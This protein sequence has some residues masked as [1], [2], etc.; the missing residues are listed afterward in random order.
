[1]STDAL[2]SVA[3]ISPDDHE[4]LAHLPLEAFRAVRER[5]ESLR[6][7]TP[8]SARLAV[9]ALYADLARF[10]TLYMIARGGS[11]HIGSSFSS[12]DIV[13]WVFLNEVRAAAGDRGFY[14]ADHTPRTPA[15]YFSSKGHD[16][17]GLYA[18]L[19]GLELLDWEKL[20][21]LRRLGG[22][23]GHPDIKTP[24]MEANTGSLG[25]GVSKAKGIAFANRLAGHD[26]QRLYVMTGDGELQEGQFW[27]SL[28]STVNGGYG[29]I[30]VIVDH[31]KFQSDTFVQRVSDLGDLEAK[32]RAYGW[33]VARCDGHD[34]PAL[35]AAVRSVQTDPARPGIVI[36]D[37]IKGRGVS[38][39]EPRNL[40]GDAL[41]LYPFHSGAPAPEKY[42]AAMAELGARIASTWAELNLPAEVLGLVT[43]PRP[44]RPN[45]DGTQKLVGA[46]SRAIVAQAAKRPNL[47]ALDADLALDTGL[48]EFEKQFPERFVE[49]GIAEMDMV[50]QAGA[51]ARKGLLPIVHSF[52]C[53]LSTRPN[54]QIFNNATE[55][56]QV[57]YAGSLAGLVPGGPGH[58]H[59]CVRDIS[60]LGGIPGMIMLEPS[61][62]TEVPL[63]LAWCLEEH[64]LASY[65]R[66]VSIPC[67]I[68]YSLPEEYTLQQ[69]R[70]VQ[71]LGPADAAGGITIIGYGP[72]LLPEAWHAAEK[73]TAAT[74]L[75]VRLF[76]LPWLNVVDP[77]WLGGAVAG[78]N[79]VVT[80]D[81][82]LLKG[83]QGEMIAATLAGQ[84][85]KLGVFPSLLH[86]GLTETP[87]C[88]LNPEVLKAHGLD[89]DSIAAAVSKVLTA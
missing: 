61:C 85:G 21:E 14:S 36:A 24:W 26:R 79:L 66:L 68:P 29:E 11:G 89:A 17:P 78:A 48:I 82:H 65:I 38:F 69:G 12:L 73:I 86:L 16:A 80:L 22:L 50:S 49:C 1:M 30:T 77:D 18:A 70:G 44:P 20:H 75:P 51:M 13:S 87:R 33:L 34:L 88:G 64:K 45:L 52:A 37:T 76:N 60:S 9:A 7:S 42:T 8:A 43:Y 40:S 54:E 59:Q 25:M 72:V 28:V 67:R 3:S 32:L 81:N 47:I 74:G 57:I 10:N 83:G 5:Y 27:E 53:F 84:A 23:P 4:T 39:M 41:R 63:V 55:R 15:L 19:L 62:E 46:Y 56:S 35:E 31:N 58:S 6:D 2:V 71:L